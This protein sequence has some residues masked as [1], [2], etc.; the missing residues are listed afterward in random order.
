V[1]NGRTYMP[2]RAISEMIDKEVFW[3]D[4]GFITV[5]DTE[6]LFDSIYDRG[7]IDYLY[8]ELNLY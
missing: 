7:L 5:S 8:E 1:I 3:D 6:N 4:C 2:L